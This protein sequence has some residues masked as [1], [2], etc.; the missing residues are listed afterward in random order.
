MD[1]LGFK[2][3]ICVITG[4]LRSVITMQT[5][6]E[7][8]FYG[9][10]DG[11]IRS[12]DLKSGK[13]T[14]V[15]RGHRA[16]VSQLIVDKS[17]KTMYSVSHDGDIRYWHIGEDA[18]CTRVVR[19]PPMTNEPTTTEYANGHNPIHCIAQCKTRGILVTDR[20]DGTLL[21]WR[22]EDGQLLKAYSGHAALITC[23]EIQGPYLYSGSRD[24]FCKV[25]NLDTDEV[26]AVMKPSNSPIKSLHVHQHWIF[27]GC[28]NGN[29]YQ[30]DIRL[31]SQVERVF[32]GHSEPVLS[33]IV[34]ED[35][36]FSGSDDTY[37]IMWSIPDARI[38]HVYSGHTDAVSCLSVNREGE[39][40][41]GSYDCSIRKWAVSG[42]IQ[43][44][45]NASVAP[46]DSNDVKKSARGSNRRPSSALSS[47]RGSTTAAA[48]AVVSSS[49]LSSPT[50][51]GGAKTS[52]TPR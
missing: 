35:Y 3:C 13:R 24:T 23:L 32:K 51:G 9:S 43:S 49:S 20:I 52:R 47:A 12:F 2:D 50:S 28:A 33:L 1:I 44:I 38:V 45:E 4:A 46:P 26:V 14:Q 17:T 29:I 16:Q 40:Y 15:Y 18:Q 39:F 34:F 6:E 22:T 37:V 7:E 31:P 11:A 8:F 48:A 36:L 21:V 41:S 25:L 42:V 30:Y 10:Y 5:L 19:N 27:V